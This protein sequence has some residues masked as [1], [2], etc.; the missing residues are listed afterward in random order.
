MPDSLQ[1]WPAQKEPE[2]SK[3]EA[4][5]MDTDTESTTRQA[6]D[7]FWKHWVQPARREKQEEE[8]RQQER[9][10]LEREHWAMIREDKD[11]EGFL[12]GLEYVV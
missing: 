12:G 9:K 5:A 4:V 7:I 6:M 1:P 2:P 3:Q 8:R 11:W 10:R